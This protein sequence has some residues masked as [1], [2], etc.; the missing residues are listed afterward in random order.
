VAFYLALT[1]DKWPDVE[2]HDPC[3]NGWMQFDDRHEWVKPTFNALLIGLSC[4]QAPPN[5]CLR[6]EFQRL[7]RGL[8]EPSWHKMFLMRPPAKHL[9]LRC[10]AKDG[11]KDSFIRVDREDGIRMVDIKRGVCKLFESNAYEQG[12]YFQVRTKFHSSLLSG[13]DVNYDEE[14]ASA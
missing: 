8:G 14:L 13:R 11:S 10:P 5:Y 6:N 12:M 1:E 4:D 2:D 9:L 3:E 7:C